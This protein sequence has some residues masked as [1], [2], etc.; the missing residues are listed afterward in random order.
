MG[1]LNVL[2][3]ER[4]RLL[5]MSIAKNT[6]KTYDSAWIRYSDFA[7]RSGVKN[8]VPLCIT[9]VS[10]FIAFLSKEGYAFSSV[11]SY[12]AGIGFKHKIAGFPDP[13][14]SFIIRKM[15]EGLNRD[16][17]HA[18]DLRLPITISHL[19]K[20]A[21]ILPII[22]SSVFEAKL[23]RAAFLLAFFGFL[24]IGELAADSKACI[25]N[26][27]LLKSDISVGMHEGVSFITICFRVSKNNQ[28]GAHQSIVI[29]QQSCALLCPVIAISDYLNLA[30]DSDVLFCHF[31]NSPLTRYQ[32]SAMLK[33][34]V[35]FCGFNNADLFTSHSFRIGAATSA[36]MLGLSD[37]EI[38]TMGRWRSNAFHNYIRVPDFS[39]A[40]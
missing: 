15:L 5:S 17:G 14:D 27:V 10:Y 40:S 4:E 25:Q 21:T 7:L 12:V 29:R 37:S 20:I 35:E 1:L 39:H 19:Q 33:K 22:T 9:D 2:A 38:Q 31:D 32:F 30:G 36:R 28:C 18:R 3:V 11:S 16:I 13:T 34:A 26:S 6:Q 23:F 8:T 24:R